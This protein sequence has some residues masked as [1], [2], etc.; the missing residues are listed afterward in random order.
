MDGA[1]AMLRSL[2]PD[3]AEVVALRVI[4]GFTVSEA[5]VMVD[6]KARTRCGP[7]PTVGSGPWRGELRRKT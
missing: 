1:L 3:Q 7:S 5:A 2:S 4:G 6:K